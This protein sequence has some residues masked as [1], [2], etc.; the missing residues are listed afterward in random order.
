MKC[1]KLLSSF[2]FPFPFL[3]PFPIGS[4]FL[5]PFPSILSWALYSERELNLGVRLPTNSIP[6]PSPSSPP[7]PP[8]C[9]LPSP[10]PS[11]HSLVA[12]LEK[13]KLVPYK[14]IITNFR[15]PFVFLAFASR[16]HL[17]FF[18]L[19][20]LP[21]RQGRRQI[22]IRAVRPSKVFLGFYSFLFSSICSG[23]LSCF[24]FAF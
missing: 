8:P 22:K 19:S 12:G 4:S 2:G 16:G 18:S 11:P 6:C 13:E 1:G 10:F 24:F 15:L 7:T 23:H 3:S 5:F 14:G 21:S 9:L 20:S 17:F